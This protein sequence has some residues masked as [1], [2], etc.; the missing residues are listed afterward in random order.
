MTRRE[1]KRRYRI[2]VAISMILAV[3]LAVNVVA[4]AVDRK[5]EKEEPIER[6]SAKDVFIEI[7]EPDEEPEEEPDRYDVF[8]SLPD[9]DFGDV[10]GFVFYELPEEYAGAGYFPEKMQK[11]TYA[12]CK[13][14]DVPYELVIAVIERESGYVF[15][16][17][18]DEG[19]SKG[20]M[21]VYEA[22][23]IDRMEELDCT[24][25]MNPYQN[26]R[27]GIDYLADLMEKYGTIQDA[28]A[29][30][31]YGEKGAKEKLWNRGVYIYSYNESIIKRM[32]EIREVLK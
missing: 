19:E 21:Q 17:I 16:E 8:D 10:E 12:L 22:Y 7:E 11:Y 3:L 2:S 15:D 28:L 27:V 31:N 18:G 25:L 4:V 9:G 20:Y 30:Y 14:Y 24:D 1:L 6:V 32:R 13:E 26:V 29:A 5:A 23:H